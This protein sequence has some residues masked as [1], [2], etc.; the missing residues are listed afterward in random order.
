VA[1]LIA[2][3]IL[4]VDSVYCPCKRSEAMIPNDRQLLLCKFLFRRAEEAVI[5]SGP[6][7]KGLAVSLA[8]DAA[9]MM[10]S[11]VLKAVDGKP[12]TFEG[13][14]KAV[15]EGLKNPQQKELPMQAQMAEV[16]KARVGFKHHAITPCDRDATRLVL[17]THEFLS[18]A[19][20]EFWGV[21]FDSLSLVDFIEDTEIAELLRKAEAELRAGQVGHTLEECAKARLILFRPF[22]QLVPRASGRLSSAISDLGREARAVAHEAKD[23]EEAFSN[24]REFAVMSALRVSLADHLR[25]SKALPAVVQS[26]AGGYQ[27]QWRRPVPAEAEARF[28]LDFVTETAL[29]VQD[30]L[31][32]TADL[33]RRHFLRGAQIPSVS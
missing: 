25:C 12:G 5:E 2:R 14:W 22:R 8:Q 13:T 19:A 33:Q 9:E 21:D 17:Y 4:A 28:A 1:H 32:G 3:Q 26:L 11:A 24:L 18:A 6:F 16:N 29:A 10:M 31:R 15:R 23:L 30:A 27:V 20:R 7:S